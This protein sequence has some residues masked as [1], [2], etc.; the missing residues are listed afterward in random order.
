VPNN[1]LVQVN[2]FLFAKPILIPDKELNNLSERD[3]WQAIEDSIS[4]NCILHTEQKKPINV[5]RCCRNVMLT[6]KTPAFV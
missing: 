2:V 3:R 4:E 1:I 6:L 5:H